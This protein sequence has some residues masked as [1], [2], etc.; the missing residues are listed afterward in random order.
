MLRQNLIFQSAFFRR[1]DWDRV[2]GFSEHILSRED[3]DFWL[4]LLEQNVGVYRIREVLFYYRKHWVRR[5]SKS[6]RLGRRAETEVLD[7]VYRNHPD[8]YAAHVDVLF[9]QIRALRTEIADLKERR[10]H[11]RL[12]LGFQSWRRETRR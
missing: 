11:E 1:A 3:Y 6:K 10:L 4:K 9:D 5:R 2:G 8:L 12:R 7:R